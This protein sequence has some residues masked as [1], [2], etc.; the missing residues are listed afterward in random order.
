MDEE[1]AF[2][3]R[4]ALIEGRLARE[5]RY[6]LALYRLLSFCEGPRT[7]E[8]IDAE[9]SGYPEM[10]V[11]PYSPRTLLSWL[12]GP[13]AVMS[14]E[15]EGEEDALLFQITGEGVEVLSS[16]RNSTPLA[17]LFESYPL[18]E[19]GFRRVLRACKQPLSREGVDELFRG[20]P[21]LENPKKIYPSFFLDK[22]ESVGGLVFDGGWTTTDEGAEFLGDE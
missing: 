11:S 13:G 17:R 21:L 1:L 5:P 6:R 7:L 16:Y 18:Y 8:E 19:E 10:A 12:V 20:D 22:L 2:E 4:V 14:L 15:D 3:E 9:V